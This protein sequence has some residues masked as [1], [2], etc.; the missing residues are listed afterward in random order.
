MAT[1]VLVLSVIVSRVAF[2]RNRTLTRYHRSDTVSAKFLDH[3]FE[4]SASIALVLLLFHGLLAILAFGWQWL[5]VEQLQRLEQFLALAQETAERYKLTWGMSLAFLSLIYLTSWM[6]IRFLERDT[7]FRMFK[8]FTRVL[9]IANIVIFLLAS[10]TLLGSEPGKA[11]TTLEI[12]LQTNRTEYGVLRQDLQR[13]LETQTV[14]HLY[15]NAVKAFPDGG[16]LPD[17]MRVSADASAA[18]QNDYRQARASHNIK[19]SR[20]DRQLR[21]RDIQQAALAR[22][23]YA[24]PPASTPSDSVEDAIVPPGVT[25]R[26]LTNIQ[27]RMDAFKEKIGPFVLKLASQ[28][29]GKEIALQLGAR[30]IDQLATILDPVADAYPVFKPVFDI[31]KSTAKDAIKIRLRQKLDELTS[32]IMQ[33]PDGMETLLPKAAQDIAETFPVK[34]SPVAERQFRRG[35]NDLQ[36]QVASLRQSTQRLERSTHPPDLTA[37]NRLPDADG[38]SAPPLPEPRPAPDPFSD[39]GGAGGSSGGGFG[40]GYSVSSCTCNTY[41]NGALVSSVPI[42]VGASCGGRICG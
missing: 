41:V 13:A 32:S 19:D 3:V 6:W 14:A 9:R 42:P 26:D 28:P 11:A 29:G 2:V 34:V 30:P 1:F 12:R 17:A 22:A 39:G 27:K 18:L 7:P 36:S 8:R 38:V 21:E 24:G 10:L 4:W 20:I 5:T 35:L 15:D 25:H 40:G 23:T 33:R 31:L 16:K 37:A